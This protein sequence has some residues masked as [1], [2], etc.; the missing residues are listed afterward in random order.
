ME[1]Q[2]QAAIDGMRKHGFEVVELETA[3]QAM[4]ND[5]DAETLR[6]ALRDWIQ[7]YE[8]ASA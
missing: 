6:Q 7:T 4:L 5:L 3:A 8:E 2:M 1:Q